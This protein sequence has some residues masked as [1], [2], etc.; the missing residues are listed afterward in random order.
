M[1][2]VVV[3]GPRAW[4]L[5]AVLRVV[6]VAERDHG[7]RTRAWNTDHHSAV[8]TRRTFAPGYAA[9]GEVTP[10]RAPPDSVAGIVSWGGYVPGPADL[11][12]WIAVGDCLLSHTGACL[13]RDHLHEPTP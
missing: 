4:L 3:T 11:P 2:G 1:V 8:T 10:H 9:G 7:R 5:L 12:T 13:R 6:A